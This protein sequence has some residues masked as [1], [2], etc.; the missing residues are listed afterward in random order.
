MPHGSAHSSEDLSDMGRAA[1]MICRVSNWCCVGSVRWE[2][3]VSLMD[4]GRYFL[5]RDVVLSLYVFCNRLFSFENL[6]ELGWYLRV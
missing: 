2:P 5:I 1:G 6:T 3:E 4:G